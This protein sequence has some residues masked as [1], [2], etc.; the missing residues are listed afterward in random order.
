MKQPCCHRLLAAV[1][2]FLSLWIGAAPAQVPTGVVDLPTRP[3]VNQRLLIL[4]PAVPKAAV[5]LFAG[6]HGGLALDS[7]GSMGWGAATS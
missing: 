1:A 4:A 2:I 3:G 6:G 5:S 7:N